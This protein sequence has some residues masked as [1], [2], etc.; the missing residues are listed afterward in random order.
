MT[1]SHPPPSRNVSPRRSS[2]HSFGFFLP[3]LLFPFPLR[4]PPLFPS[5]T[6]KPRPQAQRASLPPIALSSISGMALPSRLPCIKRDPRS[7]LP[8]PI[9]GRFIGWTVPLQSGYVLYPSGSPGFQRGVIPHKTPYISPPP[10]SIF[11]PPPL[12]ICS[13]LLPG[14]PSP[15]PDVRALTL[16]LVVRAQLC[17]RL[18]FTYETVLMFSPPVKISGSSTHACRPARQVFP[19]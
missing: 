16:G 19:H 17:E 15:L 9:A 8:P 18:Q 11:S 3:F 7:Q 14:P 6:T 4:S 2:S 5:R 1:R 12:A 13:P 10:H